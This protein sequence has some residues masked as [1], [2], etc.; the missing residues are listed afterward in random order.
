MIPLAHYHFDVSGFIQAGD[1]FVEAGHTPGPILVRSHSD[2]YDDQFYYRLAV[3]PNAHART[4]IGVTFDASAWRMQRI[5][6][7]L[8]VHVLSGGQA[9]LV[10]LMLFLVNVLGVAV[11]ALMAQRLRWQLD[12]PGWMPW[13]V[14]AWPGLF[15]TLVHDTTEI[16][17]LALLLSALSAYV[18]GRI[19]LYALLAAAATLSRE[20]SI[21]VFGGIFLNDALRWAMAR[22]WQGVERV[23]LCGL[24]LVPFLVWRQLVTWRWGISPQAEGGS[25]MGLPL[26]GLLQTLSD[27]V[28]GARHWANKPVADAINRAVIAVSATVVLGAGLWVGW[29]LPRLIRAGG[30][31]AGV[32]LGWGVLAALLS[33][34]TAGGPWIDVTGY[35]RAFSEYWAVTVVL[36]AASGLRLPRWSAVAGFVFWGACVGITA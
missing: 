6:Y 13:A 14:V 32:A 1:R 18:G 2:G 29:R 27:A 8:L 15:I 20:S 17:A 36:L 35:F 26:R 11:V 16:T 7:P 24:A 22:R 30:P 21:L 12:L 25:N 33:T 34:L 9:A 28:T 31:L 4:E 10:P 5:G 23:V 19:G 3:A